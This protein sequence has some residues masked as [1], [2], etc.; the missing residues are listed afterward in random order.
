MRLLRQ[1]ERSFDASGGLSQIRE[2]SEALLYIHVCYS[3]SYAILYGLS[4]IGMDNGVSKPAIQHV[5]EDVVPY[6]VE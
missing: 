1:Y 4:Q 3:A 6:P 5:R 2:Q